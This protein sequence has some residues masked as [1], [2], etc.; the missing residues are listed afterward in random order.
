MSTAGSIAIRLGESCMYKEVFMLLYYRSTRLAAN[1]YAHMD[2]VGY[3]SPSTPIKASTHFLTKQ[4]QTN[5][6]NTISRKHNYIDNST[7]Q[8]LTSSTRQRFPQRQSRCKLQITKTRCIPHG[9]P[10]PLGQEIRAL[11]PII[12]ATSSYPPFS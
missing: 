7:H 5:R 6:G 8:A 4:S 9:P 12:I 10:S 3:L 11:V 1:G 2:S